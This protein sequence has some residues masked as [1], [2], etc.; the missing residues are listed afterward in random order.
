MAWP[1]QERST[2]RLRRQVNRE[3]GLCVYLL[4]APSQSQSTMRLFAIAALAVSA[5]VASPVVQAGSAWVGGGGVY[6]G[7]GYGGGR[8]AGGPYRPW[9]GPGYGYGG[10]R[11]GFPGYGFGYGLGYGAGWALA[12]ASPWY[13]GGPQ[14]VYPAPSLMPFGY[15]AAP[16]VAFEVQE[17]QTYVQQAP[18]Q[19]AEQTAPSARQQAGSWYY[20]TEPAGYHPYVQQCSRPWIAVN[21][22][23]VPAAAAP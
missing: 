18:P 6:I 2:I 3:A 5:V 13:W 11:Y 7:S 17:P 10:W 22:R 12:G 15:A 4:W 14:V 20:C 19:P 9:Y 23:S 16:A 8:W 21:P 1:L